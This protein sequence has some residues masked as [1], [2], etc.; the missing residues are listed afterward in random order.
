MAAALLPG[1]SPHRRPLSFAVVVL[2][3]AGCALAVAVL[4]LAAC[5]GSEGASTAGRAT[6]E[7][8]MAVDE[9]VDPG[10]H[11]LYAVGDGRARLVWS[12]GHARAVSLAPDGRHVAYVVAGAGGSTLVIEALD[13]TVRQEIARCTRASCD[14]RVLRHAW[15]P[16]GDRL[17]YAT[18]ENGRPYVRIVSVTGEVLADI[19]PR[20]S[21]STTVFA[22]PTWSPSGRWITLVEAYWDTWEKMAIPEAVGIADADGSSWRRLIR[23]LVDRPQL[24]W[25][26]V[27]W[28]PDE[29]RLLVEPGGN[30]RSTSC[31]RRAGVN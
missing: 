25:P 5:G 19:T 26:S 15:S 22:D 6:T 11:R 16:A 30:D 28:A 18:S 23:T 14:S 24:S 27:T 20:H 10:G 2:S 12:H 17:V 29:R 21:Q 31:S 7:L 3:S 13:G 4:F 9:G 1:R 8:V